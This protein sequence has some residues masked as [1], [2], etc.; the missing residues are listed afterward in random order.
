MIFLVSKKNVWSDH[1]FSSVKKKY[2]CKY[3]N[4]SSYIEELQNFNQPDW[5]FFF[6]WSSL[7]PEEIYK[8]YRC[9]VIHTGNLPQGRGGSPIQNQI[10][11]GV[12][13]SRVNAITVE[14]TIDSGDIYHS[15][16][17]TLQGSLYD[18]WMVIAHRACSLI[19]KCV[20]E[21]LTPTQQVGEVQTYKR[22]KDNKVPFENTDNIFQIYKFI[23]MLDADGYPNPYFKIGNYKIEFSRAKIEKDNI[24]CDVKIKREEYRT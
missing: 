15:L 19:K 24:L 2:D 3:F 21:N 9:V 23:Q 7:I 11:D 13:E 5:I 4:D 10:L 17:I 6:H 18:I 8:N 1:L 16:P 12:I 20:D 14:R 22:R